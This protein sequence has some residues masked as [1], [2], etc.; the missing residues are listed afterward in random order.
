MAIRLQNARRAQPAKLA[1]LIE[2]MMSHI[3]RRSADDT[4]AVMNEAGL[5]M[6]QM[7]A[8]HLL[9]HLGPVSV[10]SIAACLKLSP[11]ATSHLVDRMVVAGLVGRTEDPIDRRH[12]R[13]EITSTGRE[14]IEGTNDRRAREFSRVLS[15]LTGE[16]Q[17][18]FGKVLARV[19]TELKGLPD[20]EEVREIVGKELQKREAQAA[21]AAGDGGKQNR[22]HRR[23]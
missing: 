1:N 14:L 20:R 13:I 19:V 9:T 4:L 15:S 10:S 22:T 8:L 18:Q 7:V 23:S 3:H 2:E 12:K 6:A 21:Q 16:V 5:T 17:A 11:P